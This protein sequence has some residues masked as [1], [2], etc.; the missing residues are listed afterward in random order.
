[1]RNWLEIYIGQEAICPDGL[2]R[3]SEIKSGDKIVSEIRVETYIKNRGC[4]WA[5][6]NVMVARLDFVRKGEYD[7]ITR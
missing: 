5:A 3:I 7:Y 6:D 1:M 2:G 4:L